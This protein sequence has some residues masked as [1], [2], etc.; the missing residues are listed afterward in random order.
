MAV[1]PVQERPYF[2]VQ[3]TVKQLNSSRGEEESE[4]GLRMGPGALGLAGGCFQMQAPALLQ[5]I[6][7][8]Q[9]T[10]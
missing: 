5:E 6:S 2:C 1:S 7:L 4:E 8:K 9:S 10:L 3:E